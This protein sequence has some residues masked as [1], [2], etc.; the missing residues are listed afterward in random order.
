VARPVILIQ[1]IILQRVW[2]DVV[3]VL[4]RRQNLI[5]QFLLLSRDRHFD[6]VPGTKRIGW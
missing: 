5:A 1:R 3:H 6:L 4:A 2:G